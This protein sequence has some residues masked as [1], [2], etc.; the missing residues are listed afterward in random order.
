MLVIN[1]ILH[2][3]R[4]E[5]CFTGSTNHCVILRIPVNS[6]IWLHCYTQNWSLGYGSR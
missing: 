4:S 1:T 3:N 6:T 2:L 5:Y